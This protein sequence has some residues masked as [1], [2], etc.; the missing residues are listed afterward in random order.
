ME[1]TTQ[2]IDD[3]LQVDSDI[4]RHAEPLSLTTVDGMEAPEGSQRLIVMGKPISGRQCSTGSAVRFLAM[5]N[6][7]AARPA[8]TVQ[9]TM[10]VRPVRVRNNAFPKLVAVSSV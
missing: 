3:H 8:T 6:I 10:K 5:K 9:A 7:P 4:W 2:P 1:Q